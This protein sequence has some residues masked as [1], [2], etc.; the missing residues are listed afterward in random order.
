M[1]F[2]GGCVSRVLREVIPGK[3]AKQSKICKWD[4][5]GKNVADQ[6]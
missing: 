4:I 3:D 5:P 6:R 1:F 2:G